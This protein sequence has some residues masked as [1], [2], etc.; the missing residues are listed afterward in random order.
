VLLERSVENIWTCDEMKLREAGAGLHREE[1][2]TCTLYQV[3]S[4]RMRWAGH[5]ARMGEMR[6]S[7]KI[8]V[9]KPEERDLSENLDVDGWVINSTMDLREIGRKGVDWIHLAQDRGS[10]AGSCKQGNEPLVP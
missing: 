1:F 6:N 2:V 10:V 7:H 8:L 3:K 4:I 9:G 5:V